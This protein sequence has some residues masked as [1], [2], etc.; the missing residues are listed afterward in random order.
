MDQEAILHHLHIQSNSFSHTNRNRRF[1]TLVISLLCAVLVCGITVAVIVLK[2]E[3]GLKNKVNSQEAQLQNVKILI[4][5][6]LPTNW[7]ESS[8]SRA[9]TLKVAKKDRE[10]HARSFGFTSGK[11]SRVVLN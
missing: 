6:L 10:K 8:S 3:A 4:D 2:R 11:V 1:A 5:K 9:I 7:S